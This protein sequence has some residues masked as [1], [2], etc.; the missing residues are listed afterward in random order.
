MQ[1]CRMGSASH[2]RNRRNA[3]L[4]FMDR[5]IGN[6]HRVRLPVVE[7]I[8]PRLYAGVRLG[9]GCG[10]WL[11]GRTTTCRFGVTFSPRRMGC[12][13]IPRQM[14]DNFTSTTI[15]GIDWII[16][17]AFSVGT[18]FGQTNASVFV[19]STYS[20]DFGGSMN[21]GVSLSQ[22]MT[23]CFS[24][25]LDYFEAKA[26]MI[27]GLPSKWLPFKTWAQDSVI[28]PSRRLPMP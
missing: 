19:G 11:K 15:S 27:K 13:P 26:S 2:P 12:Q 5:S 14:K 6:E 16:L 23:S 24:M 18:T 10:H 21:Y 25:D 3:Y 17:I 4:P 28:S 7:E 8:K 9:D 1:A 20:S 22:P